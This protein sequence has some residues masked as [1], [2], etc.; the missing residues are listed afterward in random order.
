MAIA[1]QLESIA[2]QGFHAVFYGHSPQH[3]GA[4]MFGHR[5]GKPVGHAQN[6]VY[7]DAA[8]VAG[9]V[10]AAAAVVIVAALGVCFV[11]GDMGLVA[12]H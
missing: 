4:F 7:T 11:K 3:I 12:C 2:Q 5:S 8:F 9:A 10:A 6:L 1:H